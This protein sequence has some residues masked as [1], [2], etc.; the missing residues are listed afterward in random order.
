M[1]QILIVEDEPDMLALLAMIIREKTNHK[2]TT[3]NNSLEVPNLLK[4]G[5]TI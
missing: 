2:L 3:A 1:A 4:K 5:A